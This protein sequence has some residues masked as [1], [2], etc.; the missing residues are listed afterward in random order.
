[1]II[2][3][4]VITITRHH[5]DLVID[6]CPTM[7]VSMSCCGWVVL[8]VSCCWWWADDAGGAWGAEIVPSTGHHAVVEEMAGEAYSMVREVG[9]SS[10][11]GVIL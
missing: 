5:V 10:A 9:S 7:E 4:I 2:I 11:K 3:I 6:P 1:M 8:P